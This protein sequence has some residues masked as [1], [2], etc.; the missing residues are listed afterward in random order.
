M[1]WQYQG[2]YAQVAAQISQFYT[3]DAQAASRRA[4]GYVSNGQ[5]KSDGKGTWIYVQKPAGP[6]LVTW[7][8]KWTRPDLPKI[9]PGSSYKVTSETST[10]TTKI[11]TLA[12]QTS[13]EASAKT[14]AKFAVGE[15][16]ATVSVGVTAGLAA[17]IESGDFRTAGTEE[18][19]FCSRAVE[20]IVNGKSKRL[21]GYYIYRFSSS[22]KEQPWKESTTVICQPMG[23][24]F[25]TGPPNCFP[26]NLKDPVPGGDCASPADDLRKGSSRNLLG[27]GG[28]PKGD[29]LCRA[30]KLLQLA[31]PELPQP[32]PVLVQLK[33]ACAKVPPEF[34]WIAIGG[35][36]YN[37][38][39]YI[40]TASVGV[41]FS[42]TRGTAASLGVT[43]GASFTAEGLA[44]SA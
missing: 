37:V 22:Y 39:N 24:N 7:R 3:T 12:L 35:I 1:P 13:I 43:A 11:A 4:Q 28:L 14:G 25:P 6:C 19:I 31:H 15:V 36:K 38:Q 33:S 42:D 29:Y 18:E 23:T 32:E 41:M 9:P 27:R 17:S 21:S 5:W 10:G 8:F 34:R 2:S 40:Y 20:A 16:E 26:G 30:P 44:L